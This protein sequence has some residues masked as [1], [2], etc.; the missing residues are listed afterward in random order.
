MTSP[1]GVPAGFWQRYAAWSLDAVC[2]LPL[3]AGLAWSPLQRAWAQA[4]Q[5]LKTLT[6]LLGRQLEIAL[7]SAQPPQALLPA[8][9]ADPQVQAGAAVLNAA[10]FTLFGLPVLLYALLSVLWTLGFEGSAWQATPGKRVLRLAVTDSQGG[11]PSLARLA[12]RWLAA[13]LS[14]ASL[15]LGHA[16]AAVPPHLALHDRLSG[17][18]VQTRS[19]TRRLPRWAKAWL[20]LQSVGALLALIWLWRLVQAWILAA[21]E[22][23]APG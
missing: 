14:W 3:V 7:A 15:N 9:L 17:T 20:G 12:L 5:A 11:K 21:L 18:C 16:L 19:G 6:A 8:V 2:L 1:E 22:M 10:L 4:A 23:A 13:G